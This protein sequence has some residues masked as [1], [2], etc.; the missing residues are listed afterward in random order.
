MLLC[1]CNFSA[2]PGPVNR[3]RVNEVGKSTVSLSW[4][5]PDQ[6]GGSRITAYTVEY[7]VRQDSPGKKFKMPNHF[8]AESFS[9]R[10]DVKLDCVPVRYGHLCH[11]RATC[12]W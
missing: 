6:T 12:I 3:L 2:E 7:Q 9:G 1:E 5:P 8:L 4:L 10:G 11:S